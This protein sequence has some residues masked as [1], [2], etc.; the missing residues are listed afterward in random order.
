MQELNSIISIVLVDLTS[1]QTPMR[2]RLKKATTMVP[3]TT[4]TMM[5]T[6]QTKEKLLR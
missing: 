1:T 3:H 6:L 2:S 4:M 5:V